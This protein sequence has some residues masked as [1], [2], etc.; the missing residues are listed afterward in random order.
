MFYFAYRCTRKND[1]AAI[2][3]ELKMFDLF[4]DWRFVILNS[5]L[6]YYS[7]LIRGY[8]GGLKVFLLLINISINVVIPVRSCRSC[9]CVIY[10]ESMTTTSLIVIA[11]CVVISLGTTSM[12]LITDYKDK[13]PEK[14]EIKTVSEQ[15]QDELEPINSPMSDE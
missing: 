8:I 15:S 14:K 11:C 12:A 10:Y 1:V 7:F 13:K 2:P 5:S 4:G 3:F 9:N 6:D